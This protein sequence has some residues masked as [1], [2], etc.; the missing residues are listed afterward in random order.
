M[1]GEAGNRKNAVLEQAIS[2][3]RA[4]Q[5]LDAERVYRLLLLTDPASSR[6]T[7][8]LGSLL[9]QRG[10]HEE[11]IELLRQSIASDPLNTSAWGNLGGA[12]SLCGYHKEVVA[13]LREAIRLS[14]ALP[15]AW[16]NLGV[17]LEAT[18]QFDEARA[19]YQ[20]A[21]AIKS[22]Y[23][24]AHNH[25][26]N[27]FRA[28]GRLDEAAVSHHA[29]VQINPD[30]ASACSN[31]AAA[32]GDLGRLP[33]AIHWLRH[34]VERHSAVPSRHSDLL[35][36]L[37]H[38]PAQSPEKLLAETLR[39]SERH[40]KLPKGLVRDHDN[41][42]SLHR[43]LRVGYVSCD[44]RDHPVGR[45]IA[46]VLTSH[47]RDGFEVFCY[48]DVRPPDEMTAHLRQSCDQWRDITG[49]PDAEVAAMVRA[50]QVDILVDLAGHMGRNRLPLFAY[51]A[52]PVQIAYLG[53]PATTGL[54]AIGYRITDA[55]ADPPGMT[56]QWHTEQLLRLPRCAW[57]YRPIRPSLPLAPSPVA[58]RGYITFGALNRMVKVTPEIIRLWSRIMSATP[59]SRLLISAGMDP[60][61]DQSV[62]PYF[63]RNGI[64]PD[65][66]DVV[67][68]RE[69]SRYL[70]LLGEI[71][72]ALDT[73]P[74]HGTTTTCDA[75]WSGVP[76]VSLAGRT[77]ASRVS[78]SLLLAVGLGDLVAEA[79]D[80]YVF[81]ATALAHDRDHLLELRESLR[82]R[83]RSS[84]LGDAPGLTRAL[85]Q[86]YR[87]A[88]SNW[89]NARG[90]RL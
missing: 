49:I 86:A 36:I 75:L 23:A 7:H 8:L 54:T 26:G 89:L 59:G 81:I 51:E 83:M 87:T 67:G 74:Y 78:L 37:L 38:D 69:H 72:I 30:Y 80:T 65:R 56:E 50:D 11:G 14:P 1:N 84:S 40:G 16:N 90:D 25:L 88:W 68:R 18:G 28:L 31:L 58:S 64:D 71:D 41:E 13:A 55:V 43:R 4:G 5:L 42:P 3:H 45:F 21:I 2:L 46:P 66:L 34:N 9:S 85:E 77:H 47:A 57:C 60:Y 82:D 27:A 10:R 12:L 19:A 62:R 24:E 17:A 61:S 53:Y 33:D 35:Q 22:A 63:E 48:A 15:E 20:K 70:Q 73:F 52:A 32:L 44:L 29:A 76:V 6:I 39:W 79:P